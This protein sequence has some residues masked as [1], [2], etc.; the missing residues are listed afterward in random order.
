MRVFFVKAIAVPFVLFLAAF[1]PAVAQTVHSVSGKVTDIKTGVP[2]PAANVRVAGSSS[3][4]ITNLDGSYL[5]S[6]PDGGHTLVFSYVGYRA[7][8]IYISLDS[9]TVKDVRLEP[10]EILLPEVV[11]IAEDPAYEII[12]RAIRNKHEWEKMLDS[13][14]FKGFTRMIFYRDTSIAAITESYTTGYWQRGDSLREVVT[15][16]R[17]TRN[18][19]ELQLVASVGDIINFTDDIV[20]IIGYKFVGPIAGDALDHYKYKLLRTFRK[21]GK[22]VYEIEVIPDSR[23]VPLFSGKISIADSAYA[24]IG[25]DLKP[26]DVLSIPLIRDLT[27]NFSQQYSLYE[28][29]FW[30]P[31]DIMVNFGAKISFLGLS[32]P[33][34]SFGQTSVI[35]D[36]SINAP[37]PDTVMKRPALVEDSSATK[38]DS[39]FWGAHEVLALTST[40]KRAYENLDSTQ[41]LSR[42]FKPTGAAASLLQKDGPLSYLKYVDLRFDRVE[43]LFLGGTYTYVSRGTRGTLSLSPEGVNASYNRSGWT[44]GGAAGY[45]FS[46]RVVKWQVDGTY[47]FEGNIG[48][49]LGAS[50]F[51]D[52]RHF[53][54]DEF[55]APFAVTIT[56]LFGCADYYD[57]Y[58][59]YGWNGSFSIKPFQNLVATATYLSESETSVMNHTAFSILSFGN[60]YSLNPPVPEGMMRSVSL[61]IRYGDDP[62]PLGLVPVDALELKAEYSNP[63]ILA[64]DYRFGKYEVTASYHFTTFLASYLVPPQLQ[65]MFSAGTSTGNLPLQ[66]D[67]VLDSQ[68]GGIAPFGVL[69]TAHP[70]EFIGDRFVMI[71]AEQDFRNVPFLLLGV[72]FLYKSGLELL[73][74]GSAAQ[75]WL[76]GVSTTK[77]WYYEAGFGIG[78]ILG[79]LRADF[80]WRLSKPNDLYYSVGISSIL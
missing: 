52:I 71:S 55:F 37:I 44:L 10:A 22:E 18:I 2:L 58:M 62:V 16:K 11:S 17:E 39:T 33:R 40:E 42:Q 69:K 27:F 15:Q 31:T 21:D 5:I 68:L 63:S 28:N 43:G 56:S 53:P 57:Y 6:L 38:Y 13:Y 50:V 66:R 36:Y 54:E 23:I 29:K 77:G 3:G 76:N 8:S 45:G 7:D 59:A 61:K 14:V 65:L 4:T 25:V 49:V 67:F 41:T 26:N 80:T 34:I 19:P 35:Y 46:D 12:R 24:V 9:N 70:T 78:K 75:S 48:F 79:I 60:R 72:P 74:D 20:D 1:S 73:V 32:I 51:R 64:S 30:M 47:P